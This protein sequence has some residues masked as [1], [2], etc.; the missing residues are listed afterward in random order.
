MVKRIRRD[1][2]PAKAGQ[3]E[4]MQRAIAVSHET[5]G[6]KNLYTSIVTTV[7]GARSRVHHH[8]E[9]ETSIYVLRGR[10]RFL[11]GEGLREEVSAEEGD[12]VYIPAHEVHV[13]ENASATEPLVVLLTRNCDG[14][15]VHYVDAE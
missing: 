6:S 15:V 7:A 8:G 4:A 14:P 3:N 10:A 12:F 13:E 2:I 11:S 1:E 5:C 9:C